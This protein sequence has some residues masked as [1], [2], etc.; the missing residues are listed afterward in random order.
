MGYDFY[1][2]ALGGA[3]RRAWKSTG[4]RIPILVTES[5]VA[6]RFDERRIAYIEAA[7]AEV[8]AC[9]A[10]GIDIRSYVYWSLFDNFEWAFGFKPTFGLVAV[11]R[12]T[13]ARRPKPSAYWL[14]EL[15]QAERRSALR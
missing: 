4:G 1:P 13:Q 7:I 8:K 6:T 5:G 2:Q 10:E 3:I 15:A 9:L 11:D 14:G 12:A